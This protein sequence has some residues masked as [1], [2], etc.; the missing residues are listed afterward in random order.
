M[1]QENQQHILLKMNDI[2]G[3]E[4][5]NKLQDVL[6][7]INDIYEEK[8][9]ENFYRQ[10]SGNSFMIRSLQKKNKELKRDIF[11]IKQDIIYLK[12]KYDNK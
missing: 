8:M 2:Y 11:D 10:I 5:K 7:K 4:Y 12:M 9:L 6:S 3:E 1:E